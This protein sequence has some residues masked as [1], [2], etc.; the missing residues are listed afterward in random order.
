MLLYESMLEPLL[1]TYIF[2]RPL[3]TIGD[4]DLRELL[5]EKR[6]CR[7]A[8]ENILF[9]HREYSYTACIV[10]CRSATMLKLCGCVHPMS[11]KIRKSY[12]C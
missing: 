7:F 3:E 8:D 6:G 11:P 4:D 10:E 12:Q 9:L 5:P 1:Q 2:L